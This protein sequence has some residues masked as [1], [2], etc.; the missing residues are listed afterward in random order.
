M[1]PTIVHFETDTLPRVVPGGTSRLD[2]LLPFRIEVGDP[3]V[4]VESWQLDVEV[5]GAVWSPRVRTRRLTSGLAIQLRT[6]MDRTGAFSFAH[7]PYYA[8]LDDAGILAGR[9]VYIEGCV[10]QVPEGAEVTYRLGVTIRHV[11]DDPRTVR[12]SRYATRVV[13]PRFRRDDV[14]RT[15]IPRAGRAPD[16]H[17]LLH[18][19]GGGL[20][21]IRVDVL[22]LGFDGPPERADLVVKVDGRTVVDL[23][24]VPRA[25]GPD[26]VITVPLVDI[27]ADSVTVAVPVPQE[28]AALPTV[29]VSHRQV[30]SET[31]LADPVPAVG[32]GGRGEARMMF[33]NF[34]IQGLNDLFAAP[35]D[36]YVPPRTYTELTMRDENADYSSR[37][38]APEN[39]VGDGY[40]FTVDA[41]RRFGVPQLWAMNG[42]LLGLLAHDSPDD[43]AAMAADVD[44]GVLVPVVAGYGAHRLPYYSA[45]TNLDAIEFGAQALQN[46][47]GHT[48]QVRRVYYP[49]S[50]ITVSRSN[51]TDALKGAEVEFLVVD[52]GAHED[53]RNETNIDVQN[54]DPPMGVHDGKGRFVDWQYLWYDRCSATY[55][56]FIDRETKDRL[57]GSTAEEADRGTMALNL[58][59]K[60]VEFATLDTE[61]AGNLVVYSDDADKASGNGWFDGSTGSNQRYQ[62]ALSWVAAHPWVRAVTTEGVDDA[63]CVGELDL[64]RA[65]D[66]YIQDTWDLGGERPLGLTFDTWYAA[67]AKK[68]AAWLGESL[69]AIT[70]R[71]EKAIECRLTSGG[72]SDDELIVLARLYFLM[73]L[74][75]SQWSKRPRIDPPG[76]GNADPEDFVVAE[77]IQL[78]NAH[79]YLDASFWADW[80]AAVARGTEQAGAYRDRGPV[81]TDVAT[82]AGKVFA[83]SGGVPAWSRGELVGL[84]WDHDP[85]ANVVLYNEQALV[86]IDRNGGRITHVFTMVAGRPVS[87]SG[88]HKAYQSLEL[89]WSSFAGVESDG[90]V[91]QNTV[92]TPNHAYV[93]CD[94]DASRATTGD[95][96]TPGEVYG[97]GYPDNFNAYEVTGDASGPGDAA[98][99]TLTYGSGEDTATP[100]SIAGLET[101]LAADRAA[102]V[103]GAAGIVL[104]DVEEFGRFRKTVRL[105]GRTVEVEYEDTRPGHRVANEF[106]VDLLR[107]ALHGRRQTP[108]VADDHRSATVTNADNLVV[109]LELGEGCE[110]TA[111]KRTATARP[112]AESMR[113]HRVMTDNLELVAPRG[114]AFSYRIVLPHERV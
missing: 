98:E 26:E 56:L 49:D 1:P 65:S 77:S 53:G 109:R 23:D 86:V 30:E 106:C 88:T 107:S 44:S 10:P 111:A 21:R 102:K 72:R 108:A 71:A 34:A 27:A 92:H 93:A 112:T 110:F 6:R 50:R 94:V 39:G 3:A 33:V 17:I 45:R 83:A 55:L 20:D 31:H 19:R 36:D 87:V 90:L 5:D 29:T 7:L 84:Q 40:A 28:G 63:D 32:A 103:A 11:G 113:L 22:D 47:L 59:R 97:W 38:G 68:E 104:H 60:L 48:R 15:F 43:V 91:L 74:H 62:A 105:V 101:A 42:G 89:D 70:Q 13:D 85:L 41:H 96:P 57:L 79:V 14:R 78:R 99:V 67:W 12:G 64:L 9:V 24:A 58:R 73:C 54:V 2:L 75:E 51:V 37:P 61:R 25:A 52:A 76:I 8:V 18:R 46:I 82:F 4:Q 100:T 80:V 81:I 16:A 69:F 66:P 95:S 35:D 114:G